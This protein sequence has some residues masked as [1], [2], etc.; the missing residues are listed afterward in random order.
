MAGLAP[1]RD[2]LSAETAAI[3]LD[4]LLRPLPLI[5]ATV[6]SR[7]ADPVQAVAEATADAGAILERARQPLAQLLADCLK[8]V[9]ALPAAVR[10]PC[11]PAWEL[12][13]ITRIERYD[14]AP[15]LSV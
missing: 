2:E 12:T 10:S 15:W 8:R 4:D 14:A 5:A 13:G 7:A 1:Y 9:A 3:P 11:R 6:G